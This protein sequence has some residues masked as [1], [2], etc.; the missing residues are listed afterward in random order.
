[1]WFYLCIYI[2]WYKKGVYIP[3]T[4]RFG[5]D[6]SQP[7][8]SSVNRA[9]RDRGYDHLAST[10]PRGPPSSVAAT[11]ARSPNVS[12]QAAASRTTWE[13]KSKW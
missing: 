7:N 8:D 5:T 13:M 9:A 11:P 3:S 12:G 6:F 4:G 1:M 10:S 2:V